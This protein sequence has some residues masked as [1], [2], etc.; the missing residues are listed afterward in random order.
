[1]VLWRKIES[2]LADQHTREA[3]AERLA[4]EGSHSLLG[5]FVLGATDG[6]ITTFAIVAGVAGAQLSTAVAFVLGLAN[7][8]ADGFSMATSNYLKTHADAHLVQHRRRQEEQHILQVPE[9]EREEVRQIF[10]GKGF[11]GPVLEEIVETIT[12]DRERWIDTMITEEWGLPL[13]GPRPGI[14]AGMTF[15]AFVAA[16]LLPLAPLLATSWLSADAVFRASAAMTAI[17]F[18]VIGYI[19]GVVGGR[20]RWRCA[21]E[22]LFIGGVAAGLAYLVGVSLRG[23]LEP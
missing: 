21:L 6:T 7:V 17:S 14:V 9:G 23:I 22:T 15:A 2:T 12:G 20:G 4:R 3:I 8:L 19:R 11:S 1:M 5:D 16:G 13:R 18:L 10:A